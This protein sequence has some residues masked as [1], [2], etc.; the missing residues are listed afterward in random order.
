[1]SETKTSK[2]KSKKILQDAI[3][4]GA[5][6]EIVQRYGSAVKEHYVAYSGVDNE[7]GKTLSK[8]LKSIHGEKINPEYEYQNI[9]QQAGFSAEIKDVAN[10]NGENTINGDETR[11]IRTD[12]LG[13]VNDRLFDHVYIDA[14]GNIIQ[15]SGSQ[16]KFI[17]MSQN[18]VTG[19]GVPKRIVDRLQSKR[20]EKYIDSK[21][22][23]QSEQYDANRHEIDR[24]LADSQR[25]LSTAQDNGKTDV[26]RKKTQEIEKL[27]KIKENLKKST[28]SS[29]EA[30]FAREHPFLST[31]QSSVQISHRA[32]IEAVKYGAL[33]GGSVSIAK[34]FV[35]YSKG[36]IGEDEALDNVLKDTVYCAIASYPRAAMGSII[37]GAMQNSRN[38]MV[39]SISNSNLPAILV[40]CA[41]DAAKTFKRYIDSEIDGAE[42][43]RELGQQGAN[44]ISALT[45]GAVGQAVIPIPVVGALVGTMI[46]YAI[47]SASYGALTEA[48]SKEKIATERRK[49]I[50]KECQEHIALIR[51][52]RKEME[53]IIESYLYQHKA[54]FE[55]ALGSLQKAFN[56][57]DVDGVICGA[58]RISSAL[59]RSTQFDNFDE[60]DKLM[61][62]DIPIKF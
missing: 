54:I 61:K 22:E 37:K 6:A 41:F 48:L 55:D 19:A 31:A 42:C 12:D 14:K 53:K 39:R 23:I 13:M 35:A 29:K 8:S 26:V 7:T 18:D 3:S 25:Q 27:K 15:G 4:E 10:V 60:F 40:T 5:S 9:H 38:A 17:G 56:T 24:R 62:S 47:S 34:N 58:N 16:T 45:F 1:M 32:G 46:G 49:A 11:K 30:L 33:V 57:G 52:N 44:T 51:Q 20:F 36:E 59:G 43:F 2:K 28:V 21:I 50:E